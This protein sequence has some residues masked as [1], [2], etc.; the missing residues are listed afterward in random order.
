MQEPASLPVAKDVSGVHLP[1]ETLRRCWAAGTKALAAYR[2][3]P[4]VVNVWASWCPPC[5]QEMPA[6][7]QVHEA[8][9]DR[10]R[11]VGLD[12]ADSRSDA[13]SFA[14]QRGITYDLLFDP[15][16]TFAPSSASP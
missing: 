6:F 15:D 7:Q 4:L 12:R 16:D 14:Q 11:F 5:Q 2:G 8:L 9:G 10:V 1:D 3:T 13:A